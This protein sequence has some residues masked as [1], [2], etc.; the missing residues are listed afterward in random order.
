MSINDIAELMH[1]PRQSAWNHFADYRV[2]RHVRLAFGGPCRARGARAVTQSSLEPWGF[3]G[4]KYF[5]PV[6][7]A[8][9]DGEDHQVSQS[10]FAS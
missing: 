10:L 8:V 3:S 9:V 5:R 4:L 1:P 2:R 6:L 7:R